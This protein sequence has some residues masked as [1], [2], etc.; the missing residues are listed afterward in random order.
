MPSESPDSVISYIDM[1][2]TSC[3]PDVSACP[4]KSDASPPISSKAPSSYHAT[5]VAP[6][7]STEA[8]ESYTTVI[9]ANYVGIC[10]TGYTT[11]PYTTTIVTTSGASS[12]PAASSE[13]PA[14]FA[15]TV[16]VCPAC[17][18]A[19]PTIKLTVPVVSVVPVPV[20][21]GYPSGEIPA[22]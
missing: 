20:E 15:T 9:T 21:T 22:V 4:T 11:I 10:P 6:T 8:T 12:R 19:S 18:S 7:Q 5:S 17:S 14:G 3:A 1:T 13:V 2:I 16:V